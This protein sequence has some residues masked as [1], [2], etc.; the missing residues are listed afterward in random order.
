MLFRSLSSPV[1]VVDESGR[2]VH[3]KLVYS[4]HT[5]GPSVFDQPVFSADN[6]PANMPAIWDIQYGMLRAAGQAVVVGEWGG[7][8]HGSDAV[9]QDRFSTYLAA[10]GIGSFYWSLNPESADTGGLYTEWG[11]ADAAKLDLT[12]KLRTTKV[13]ASHRGERRIWRGAD[14]PPPHPDPP[15][16]Y[17]PPPP[18]PLFSY[19]SPPPRGILWAAR[20]P[21]PVSHQATLEELL[22]QS[23]RPPNPTPPPSEPKPS[24]G[25]L[26]GR[27]TAMRALILAAL[28]VFVYQTLRS[29]RQYSAGRPL[30]NCIIERGQEMI[31]A[32]GVATTGPS[33][34]RQRTTQG[35]SEIPQPPQQQ[36][37]SQAARKSIPINRTRLP[38]P[39]PHRPAKVTDAVSS[40]AGDE[41]GDARVSPPRRSTQRST[42]QA[43]A[44]PQIGTTVKPAQRIKP[45]VHGTRYAKIS[46][47]GQEDMGQ[48]GVWL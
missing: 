23:V 42:A 8:L 46:L 43:A 36:L 29:I 17:S 26:H 3:G 18:L 5:Y 22:R 25:L 21:A 38:R 41:A 10:S 6:F 1:K 32:V 2:E 47:D 7:K 40:A 27:N 45:T 33:G 24:T 28:A 31:A 20:A 9:W 12:A 16:I 14:S 35:M 13:P 37:Q 4:P 15:L 19:P 48:D 11:V 44:R 34:A 39:I 30:L